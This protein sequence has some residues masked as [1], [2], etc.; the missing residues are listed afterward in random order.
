M[1]V[2]GVVGPALDDHVA[3]PQSSFAAFEN[4]RCSSLQETDEVRLMHPRVARL[5]YDVTSA[6]KFGKTFAHGSVKN[7]LGN[8]LGLDRAPGRI[9]GEATRPG[10]AARPWS[11]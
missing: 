11:W 3:R 2:P 8:A 6:V 1:C 10:A 4:Q 9:V 5:I 7:R